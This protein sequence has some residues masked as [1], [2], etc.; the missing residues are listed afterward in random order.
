MKTMP[1][2]NIR[3]PINNARGL[4]S[5]NLSHLLW[6]MMWYQSFHLK[7]R[8]HSKKRSNMVWMCQCEGRDYA[9]ITFSSKSE[10]GRGTEEIRQP[11]SVYISQASVPTASQQDGCG[12]EW[13]E[14]WHYAN[15]LMSLPVWTEMMSS[16][17]YG[18]L[19]SVKTL[20]LN[21]V[22]ASVWHQTGRFPNSTI[23]C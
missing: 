16:C 11:S 15:A 19:E 21:H 2:G 14:I 4:E 12:G 18:T 13:G 7:R 10:K 9:A 3:C 17:W 22:T 5:Q 20:L 8:T 23:S 1:S 6:D